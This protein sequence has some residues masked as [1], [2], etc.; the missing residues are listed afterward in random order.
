LNEVM[1]IGQSRSYVC[2]SK[3]SRKSSERGQAKGEHDHVDDSA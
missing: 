3:L 1:H 2:M